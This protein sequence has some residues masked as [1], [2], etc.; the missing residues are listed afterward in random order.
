MS[1]LRPTDTTGLG[2]DKNEFSH[3]K[4]GFSDLLMATPNDQ[5]HEHVATV[6]DNKWNWGDN[7]QWDSFGKPQCEHKCDNPDPDYC[8]GATVKEGCICVTCKE[9]YRGACPCTTCH[10]VEQYC[11]NPPQTKCDSGIADECCGGGG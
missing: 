7:G 8:V 3:T 6:D 9:G 2:F 11:P 4:F 10:P 5:A 1:K